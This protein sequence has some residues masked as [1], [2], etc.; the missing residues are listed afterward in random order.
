M[1]AADDTAKKVDLIGCV[2]MIILMS[3]IHCTNYAH[4]HF[5]NAY[6]VHFCSVD[7]FLFY[8]R[9]NYSWEWKFA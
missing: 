9:K 5:L 8:L 4:I 6:V 7:S 3:A 1:V 2:L